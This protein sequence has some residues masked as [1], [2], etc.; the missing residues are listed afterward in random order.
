M[1]TVS[2]NLRQYKNKIENI[3]LVLHKYLIIQYQNKFF[4]FL[5]IDFLSVSQ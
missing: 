4:V 2:A 3:L 1:K 5:T